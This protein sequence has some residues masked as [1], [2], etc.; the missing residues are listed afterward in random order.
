MEKF[1]RNVKDRAKIYIFESVI[2][3]QTLYFNDLN[4]C[5]EGFLTF[6]LIQTTDGALQ[7]AMLGTSW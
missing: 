5:C 3:Y 2:A 7:A 6:F 1:V 4:P